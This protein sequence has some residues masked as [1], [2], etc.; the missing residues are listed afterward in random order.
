M[1]HTDQ[2]RTLHEWAVGEF[3]TAKVIYVKQQTAIGDHYHKKKDEHFFLAKG[4]I[5]VLTIGSLVLKNIH[6]PHAFT[7]ERGEYH[8]FVMT[9]GS[10]LFGVTTELFDP[11]DE[12]KK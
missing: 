5:K 3:K 4:T 11:E 6:A 1:I 2:R 8:K 7:V 10:I 12:I 9:K